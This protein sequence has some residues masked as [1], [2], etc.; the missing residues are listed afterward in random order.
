MRTQ[1][2]ACFFFFND[3]ATT[4]IYTLPLHDA[5]PISGFEYVA[6][7]GCA[8]AGGSPPEATSRLV[9][10]L[11]IIAR[12]DL[13]RLDQA[14]RGFRRGAAR[15]GAAVPGDIFETRDRESVV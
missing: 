8:A 12:D 1:K 10:A 11:Q 4:E 7:N 3:T 14:A 5:L 2:R 13:Q 6:W 15:R 9:E